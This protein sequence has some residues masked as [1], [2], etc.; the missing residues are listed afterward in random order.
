MKQVRYFCSTN[1]QLNEFLL[2]AQPRVQLIMFLFTKKFCCL[3]F[4][5]EFDVEIS[6]QKYGEGGY[7]IQSYFP[8]T[9]PGNA[10]A[11]SHLPVTAIVQQ[12][13]E[14]ESKIQL[15]TFV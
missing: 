5:Q 13:P 12:H 4:L 3:L 11:S 14:F 10:I 6:W 15:Q 2:Y 1:Y 7:R 8:S 9:V